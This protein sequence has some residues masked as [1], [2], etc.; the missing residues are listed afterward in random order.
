MAIASSRKDNLKKPQKLMAKSR[1]W[2]VSTSLRDGG[3]RQAAL[4][5]I[6]KR[7]K[8]LSC[9]KWGITIP[10]SFKIAISPPYKQMAQVLDG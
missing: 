7:Y 9:H 6:G 1:R 2:S 10:D 4:K 3:S 5:A 8:A